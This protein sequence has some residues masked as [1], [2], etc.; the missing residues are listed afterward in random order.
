VTLSG[1]ATPIALTAGGFIIVS[2]AGI[3]SLSITASILATEVS[4]I[5]LGD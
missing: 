1:S 3:T 5:V 4:V 2:K